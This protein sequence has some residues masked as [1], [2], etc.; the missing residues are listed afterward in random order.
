[1]GLI[2]KHYVFPFSVRRKSGDLDSGGSPLDTFVTVGS[3]NGFIEQISGIEQFTNQQRKPVDTI[4]VFCSRAIPFKNQDQILYKSRIYEVEG[5]T[6]L[7]YSFLSN[8]HQEVR[9]VYY[10]DDEGGDP[11]TNFAELD[12]TKSENSVNLLIYL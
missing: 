4:R 11:V 9:A 5:I 7:D 6:D 10:G 12:F 8:E 3:Y 1:M 2:E